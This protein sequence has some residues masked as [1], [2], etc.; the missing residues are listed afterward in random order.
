[1]IEI[2]NDEDDE[3]GRSLLRVIDMMK[4][5]CPNRTRTRWIYPTNERRTEIRNHEDGEYGGSLPIIDQS[6]EMT[7]GHFT[8]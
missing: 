1:M 6:L 5:Q 2:R 4:G 7:K 3:Y 8:D